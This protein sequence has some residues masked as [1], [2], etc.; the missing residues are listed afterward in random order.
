ML[1]IKKR[2]EGTD[3]RTDGWTNNLEAIF[4]EVGG[5]KKGILLSHHMGQ[6]SCRMHIM[7]KKKIMDKGKKENKEKTEKMWTSKQREQWSI[8]RKKHKENEIYP[9]IFPLQIDRA[10]SRN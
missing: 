5:I 8:T 7:K 9:T 3:G 1:C 10:K 6:Q 4:F 2:D